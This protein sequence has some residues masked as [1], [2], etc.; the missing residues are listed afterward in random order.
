M[1]KSTISSSIAIALGMSAFS[2]QAELTTS[3]VLEFEQGVK[4]QVCAIPDGSVPP[5]CSYGAE[6]TVTTGSFF[7]MDAD[8][9]GAVEPGEITVIGPNDG[10]TIGV[11]QSA[12]GSHPGAPNGTENEGLDAAWLFFTNT[13]M[14]FTTTPITQTG[15]AGT[16][17]KSLDFSGWRVTWSGIPEIN[18][19]GGIQ[20]CGTTD[21]G[22]CGTG[23]NDI[24]GTIDNGSQ[25]ASITCSTAS[26]SQ[27]STFVLDYAATVPQDDPS[28]F[29][30]V[31]YTL[32]MEGHIGTAAIPVPAAV[33]LFGSGLLGLVGVAR[34][35]KK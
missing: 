26:C 6:N 21:D 13:G 8:G 16:D 3:A 30:G 17:T 34:R 28:G 23:A 18:M 24:G 11:A 32:H 14:H 2:V 29:G 33:W 1:K 19:G 25:L 22:I 20:D 9:S 31:P 10:V 4:S 7:T 5:N 12:S 27:S 35:R 15:G